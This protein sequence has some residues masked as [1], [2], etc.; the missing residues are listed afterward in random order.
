MREK[1]GIVGFYSLSGA[2]VTP[3]ILSSLEALQHRGQESWGIAIEGH[4]PY[5]KLGLVPD[6]LTTKRRIVGKVGI[7]HVRYSTIGRTTLENAQPIQI[8]NKFSIAQNGT[9]VN[10]DT[11]QNILKTNFAI[12]SYESDTKLIGLRLYQLLKESEWLEAFTQIGKELLGSYCLTILNNRCEVYGIRD[13]RGFRPLCIGWHEPSSSY[14]I[15]S[16]SCVLIAIGAEFIR[17]VEPGEVVKLSKDGFQSFRFAERVRHYHCAFE[18][19]YFAHP[20]SCIDGVCV[21]KVRKNIGRIL[22]KKYSGWGD[23]VIPVPDSARPAAL[24]YSEV[25]GI[26]FEEG[27]MKDRYRKRGMMR[28]FIEPTQTSREEIVKKIIPITHNVEGKDIVMV[29]DSIVRGTSSKIIVKLLKR[30]GARRI[31]MVVTFP[32]IRYPC[33]MGIDFPTQDEL[34]AYK[35][36]GE[37]SDINKINEIV[38]AEI[39]VDQLGY[40]DIE[41]LVEGIGLPKDELCLACVTG[42][43][44]CIGGKPKFRSREELKDKW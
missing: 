33:Y 28:S 41:G 18:Y 1:C 16:E 6:V 29:D 8:G 37:E 14:L 10:F 22:A 20:S 31:R 34:L 7:G 40:N 9:I 39:G 25:S 24:G 42:D 35:L 15:A 32:P 19:T 43:Y 11:L 44:S 17:D 12:K 38:G 5:R 13:P 23:I 3:L 26:T 21:Y 30:A 27:L 4:K 2:N 36:C